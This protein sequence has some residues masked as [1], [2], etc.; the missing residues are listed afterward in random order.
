MVSRWVLVEHLQLS[1]EPTFNT[2]NLIEETISSENKNNSTVVVNCPGLFL[3]GY[4]VSI[5][6]GSLQL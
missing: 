1:Y 3:L 2:D 4:I 6:T 5:L